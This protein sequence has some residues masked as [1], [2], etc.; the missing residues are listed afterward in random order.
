MDGDGGLDLKPRGGVHFLR[1]N[2]SCPI[3]LTHVPTDLLISSARVHFTSSDRMTDSSHG[4]VLG[5]WVGDFVGFLEEKFIFF[6]FSVRKF[7]VVPP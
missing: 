6:N 2:M 7:W 1:Q 5:W 3:R 4:R